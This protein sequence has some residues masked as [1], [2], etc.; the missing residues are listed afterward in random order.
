MI[1]ALKHNDIGYH[2]NL[3]SVHPAPA[4]YLANCGL[5]DGMEEFV[6][7]EARARRRRAENLRRADAGLLWPARLLMGAAG[8]RRAEPVRHLK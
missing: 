6:R 2:S 3:H 8:G 4:E 1:D 5:L 7:H